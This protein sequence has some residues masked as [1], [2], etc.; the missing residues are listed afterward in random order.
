EAGKRYDIKLEF[1]DDVYQATMQLRWSSA[2]TAKAFIPSANLFASAPPVL[3][4]GIPGPVANTGFKV[5][6][7]DQVNRRPGSPTDKSLVMD[8]YNIAK[9]PIDHKG[10]NIAVT[11]LVPGQKAWA[12]R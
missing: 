9:I 10:M 7:N 11:D 6:T 4:L 3:D 12:Y 2:G 8:G 1:Y 5:Y